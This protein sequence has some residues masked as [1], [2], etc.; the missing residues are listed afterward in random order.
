MLRNG[1]VLLYKI[2]LYK[3][4]ELEGRSDA[5]KFKDYYINYIKKIDDWLKENASS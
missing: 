3:K 1:Y 4:A 2:L 5:S